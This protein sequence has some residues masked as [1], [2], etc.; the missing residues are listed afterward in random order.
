MIVLIA[1]LLLG[2][3]YGLVW[4]LHGFGYW[5]YWFGG[6]RTISSHSTSNTHGTNGPAERD[7]TFQVGASPTLILKTDAGSVTIKR[8]SS[9]TIAVQTT[10]HASNGGNLNDMQVTYSQSD[11]TVNV[12]F[13]RAETFNYVQGAR[14]DFTISVPQTCDLQ[15]TTRSGNIQVKGI[16]GKMSLLSNAGS[17]RLT[18]ASLSGSSTVK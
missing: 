8:G 7:L 15:L 16:S 11:S 6:V 10:K 14:V 18:D 4:T 5:N 1:M 9:K 17:I 12:A 2:S 13:H 3:G